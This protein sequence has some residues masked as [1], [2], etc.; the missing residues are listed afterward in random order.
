MYIS[1]YHLVN[2]HLMDFSGIR[3]W[4]FMLYIQVEVCWLVTPCS[5]VLGYQ[6]L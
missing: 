3:H 6:L 2:I 1:T 4:I 5:V